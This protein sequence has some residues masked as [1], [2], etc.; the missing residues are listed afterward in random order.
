MAVINHF[1]F[2]ML[3]YNLGMMMMF[4][5]YTY[6][7]FPPHHFINNSCI[8]LN[9]LHYLGGNVL[10]DVVRYRDAMMTISIETDGGLN[11]LKKAFLID[12]GYDETGFVKGFGAF[13]AGADADGGEWVANTGEETA[14]LGKGS[15][16]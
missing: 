13:R 8:A 3:H 2:D 4:I 16:V 14:F 1:P 10:L 7:R 11:S 9:N 15:T 5:A 6:S 12:A